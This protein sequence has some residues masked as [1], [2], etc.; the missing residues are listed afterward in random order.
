MIPTEWIAYRCKIL[1]SVM[2]PLL[3]PHKTPLILLTPIIYV[4]MSFHSSEHHATIIALENYVPTADFLSSVGWAQDGSAKMLKNK[5]DREDAVLIVIGN[6]INSHLFCGLS[7]NWSSGNQY[8]NLNSAKYSFS[9]GQPDD[10]VFA[11]DF[12]ITFKNLGKLQS[13]VTTTTH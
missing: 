7:G 4:N 13:T 9:I 2:A 1:P 12:N 3:F 10:K 8:G 6:V 11:K 5:S